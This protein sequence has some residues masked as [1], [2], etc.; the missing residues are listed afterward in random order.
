MNKSQQIKKAA[1]NTRKQMIKQ[2]IKNAVKWLKTKCKNA[3]QYIVRKCN[4]LWNWLKKIDIVGMINLTLLTA[5]IVLVIS[6]FTN[7]NSCVKNNVVKNNNQNQIVNV[8]KNEPQIIRHQFNT[9]LPVRPDAKTG[10]KP[11]IKVVGNKKPVV[12]RETSVSQNELPKQVLSG[13]VIVDFDASAPVLSNGVQINGNLFVQ[14]M[15][16]YTLPCGAKIEGHLFIRNVDKLSFCGEFTVKG[17]I[18]VNRQSSFG[19]IPSNA[20]VGGQV[21]L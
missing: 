15:R 18:Y 16:K 19:P 3:W 4:A 1:H 14:N 7:S 13:D 2:W 11:Q 20:R 17:N 9:T 8:N 10:L 21:M 5:I 12:V 6:L